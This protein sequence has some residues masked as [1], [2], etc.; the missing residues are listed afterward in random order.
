MT[1]YTKKLLFDSSAINA[2][3]R[4]LANDIRA[5]HPSDKLLFVGILKGS[6]MFMAD[7]VRALDQ[8]CEID[9]AKI[10]SYGSETVSSGKLDVIMDVGIPLKDRV[11][12]L[13]DDIVDTGLTLSEYRR[14]LGP[15]RDHEALAE[16][17]ILEPALFAHHAMGGGVEVGHETFPAMLAAALQQALPERGG[18]GNS[19]NTSCPGLSRAFTSLKQRAKNADGRNIRP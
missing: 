15:A 4:E 13:V 17:E 19:F 3:V 9:F 12:I 18:C 2:R 8:H 6:F 14:R 10:S 7:L 16:H 11:V 1:G 5:R